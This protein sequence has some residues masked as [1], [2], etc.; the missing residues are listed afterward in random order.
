MAT[1]TYFR[2]FDAR[3]DQ[4]LLHSLTTE[5]I[6]IHGYDVNYI[7]RTLVNEDK[8]LGKRGIQVREDDGRL[9]ITSGSFG[10]R[11]KIEI[12][13]GK[14][15]DLS[16]LGLSNGESVIGKDVLGTIDG[17]KAKGRGQLLVGVE[18]NPS[19]GLRV[20]VNINDSDLLNDKEEA[21]IKLKH[22]LIIFI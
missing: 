20:Y 17:L 12:E 16:N 7:P 5:S 21:K 11:S 15:I 10:S 19:E 9:K 2:N 18:G 13:P 6:Q 14:D 8:I 4:E 22:L 1:S 3:N